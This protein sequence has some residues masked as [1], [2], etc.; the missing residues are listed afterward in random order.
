VKTSDFDYE[1][2]QTAIAA[3][4]TDPR[5]AARLLVHEIGADRTSHRRVRDLPQVLA[6]GDLLVVNDT[7]VR[8]ARLFGKRSGGGAIELLLLAPEPNSGAP[9]RPSPCEA[10]KALVKP[11]RRLEPGEIFTLEDGAMTGRALE[12]LP[13]A[14]GAPGAEWIVELRAPHD[15]HDVETLVERHGRMP[16][17]PYLRR[18]RG[19]EPESPE[20]RERYQTVYAS[21]TGA[22]AA[23][24]AGLHFTSGLLGELEEHG[25]ARAALTLHV[26]LGTFQ[27]IEVED[28]AQHAM[29][30]E[31][32]VLPQSAADAVAAARARSGRVVAVG[33]TSF[34]VLEAC[35]RP[36]RVVEAGAG[37]T[38][39]FVR[40]GTDVQVVD[41]LFTNFHLPRSTLLM[42][43]SAFA[44]RERILR[45]YKEAL[46]EGYR[47]FSYG[48]AML[49]L[50]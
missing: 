48:D 19:S 40:P 5:D 47:F 4:P 16:L 9:R 41:V 18:A 21:A 22:V 15:T 44:G 31:D 46:A 32:Y 13:R 10:W 36:G 23:P 27:P 20:D 30:S 1:L 49:L 24:T 26:G 37:S 38:R 50:P 7:R 45:L 39:L 42:L 3:H 8:P 35:A 25:I 14:D 29:H 33:T 28:P 43:V 34:R 17:P 6:A 2:P 11:A 12:R